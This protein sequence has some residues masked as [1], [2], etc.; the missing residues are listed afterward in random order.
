ML[1][2]IIKT[3]EKSLYESYR[4]E[5]EMI[6]WRINYSKK[7]KP[8]MMLFDWYY[9]FKTDDDYIDDDKKRIIKIYFLGNK[10]M[11]KQKYILRTEAWYD[12][13]IKTQSHRQKKSIKKKLW[14]DP[15]DKFF[16][17]SFW[18]P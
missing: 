15:L 10:L 9:N 2:K 12:G 13:E 8:Q 6:K 11:I 17:F 3:K 16:S 14:Q 18:Y 1:I 7:W 5:K 4:E